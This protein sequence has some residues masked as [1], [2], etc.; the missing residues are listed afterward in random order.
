MSTLSSVPSPHAP[1]FSSFAFSRSRQVVASSPRPRPSPPLLHPLSVSP[2][3]LSRQHR[4]SAHC[5]AGAGGHA[6]QRLRP[7]ENR[8]GTISSP[9]SSTRCL[10]SFCSSCSFF[11]S[12]SSASTTS[13]SSAG[14][15]FPYVQVIET[16][17]DLSPS[18]FVLSL[19]SSLCFL[20]VSVHA[21]TQTYPQTHP[22]LLT[23]VYTD[24]HPFHSCLHSSL[25]PGQLGGGG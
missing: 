3:C 6:S 23:P 10:C 25:V 8:R 15:L 2:L 18:L 13:P 19:E 5:A 22:Q 7:L 9:S 11:F 12:S 4:G 17:I 21:R 20:P 1:V 14:S 16:V 24:T